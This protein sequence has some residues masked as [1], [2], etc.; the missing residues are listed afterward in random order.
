MVYAID[1]GCNRFITMRL[2]NWFDTAQKI[3]K[4]EE[5]KRLERLQAGK[6]PHLAAQLRARGEKPE[7]QEPFAIDP[8][9]RATLLSLPNPPHA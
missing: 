3:I 9:T 2:A 5:A 7:R 1:Q 8:E 4:R 6:D